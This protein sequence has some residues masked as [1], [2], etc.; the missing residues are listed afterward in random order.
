MLIEK[1]G[2]FDSIISDMAPNFT[3]VAFE[4]HEEI[5]GLNKMCVKLAL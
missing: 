4:T 5:L 3:G 1:Y 2:H